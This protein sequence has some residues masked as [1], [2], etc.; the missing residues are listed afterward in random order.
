MAKG[1][2]IPSPT[3]GLAQIVFASPYRETK[4]VIDYVGPHPIGVS[5]IHAD[6]NLTPEDIDSSHNLIVSH[7]IALPS[8]L[9]GISPSDN[10]YYTLM[11]YLRQQLFQSY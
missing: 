5:F 4:P 8:R 2:I 11:R 7:C 3:C 9:W 10:E 1:F 6:K